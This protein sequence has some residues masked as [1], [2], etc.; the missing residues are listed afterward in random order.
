MS[1]ILFSVKGKIAGKTYWI[2][3]QPNNSST[4]K[5]GDGIK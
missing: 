3:P 4:P 1:Q 2:D 5:T